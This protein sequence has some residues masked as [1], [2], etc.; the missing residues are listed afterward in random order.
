MHRQVEAAA[1]IF[2]EG[3][4]FLRLNTGCSRHMQR[5]AYNDVA[6]FIPANDVVKT[7][8]VGAFVGTAKGGQP[9]RCDAERIGDCQANG[10]RTNIEPEQP[11]GRTGFT[12]ISGHTAI[13][14][15]RPRIV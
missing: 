2:G 9:L 5:V 11:A 3:L 14:G 8:Q 10:A 12:N 15:T 6:H 7:L 13:I 1:Q 4:D